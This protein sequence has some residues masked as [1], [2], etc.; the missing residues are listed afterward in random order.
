M[1]LRDKLEA[2]MLGTAL[3]MASNVRN[4]APAAQ[5]PMAMLP[6]GVGGCDADRCRMF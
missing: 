1:T 3:T 5:F 6:G 4:A 2:W